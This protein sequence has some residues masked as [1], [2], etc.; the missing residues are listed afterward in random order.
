M[1][2]NNPDDE[3]GWSD[4]I[5]VFCFYFGLK[6]G[7]GLLSHVFGLTPPMAYCIA[8]LVC[9]LL[10]YPAYFCGRPY[11]WDGQQRPWTFRRYLPFSLIGSILAFFL[12]ALIE[13]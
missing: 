8:A 1:N 4:A 7:G 12:A 2:N 3:G 5:F 13:F 9:S 6:A 10:A 11:P